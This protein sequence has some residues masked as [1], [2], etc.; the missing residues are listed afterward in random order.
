MSKDRIEANLAFTPIVTLPATDFSDEVETLQHDIGALGGHMSRTAF[1]EDG[2]WYY[3]PNLIVENTSK[4]LIGTGTDASDSVTALVG[5][6]G[7][8]LN[9]N[10]AAGASIVSTK[11]D[12]I[13]A[14]L[15]APIFLYIKHTGTSDISGTTTKERLLLDLTG[16]TVSNTTK[17]AI[18]IDHG[19]SW[20]GCLN[21][22]GCKVKNLS[23]IS[24]QPLSA[25]SGSG[26]IRCQVAM[27]LD[28]W[29]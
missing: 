18:S 7:N 5:A 12:E 22:A 4:L 27:M 19:Q 26:N 8:Q 11:A 29:V 1:D 2:W 9:P 16:G 23:A 21:G 10:E 14:H 24:V 13:D 20:M 3:A 25:G 28:N 6:S 15:D 17:H